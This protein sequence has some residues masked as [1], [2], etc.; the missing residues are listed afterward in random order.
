[1]ICSPR[2][3]ETMKNVKTLN[4]LEPVTYRNQQKIRPCTFWCVSY[5]YSAPAPQCQV[6]TSDIW[7]GIPIFVIELSECND[8]DTDIL[9]SCIQGPLDV[10]DL[11]DI[12]C[13]GVPCQVCVGG[14]I[15]ARAAARQPTQNF[16]SSFGQILKLALVAKVKFKRFLFGCKDFKH[17]L[18]PC[19]V[20]SIHCSSRCICWRFVTSGI[21]LRLQ[22]ASRALLGQSKVGKKDR[23]WK[24]WKRERDGESEWK[25]SHGPSRS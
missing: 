16:K 22:N 3:I 18:K 7:D 23:Q 12:L 11:L 19:K 8:S 4:L 25:D 21:R 15:L 2:N 9:G 1:M 5:G 6:C 20:R 13:T 14:S 10:L 17:S 24:R